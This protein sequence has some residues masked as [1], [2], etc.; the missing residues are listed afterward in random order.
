MTAALKAYAVLEKDE[1][2][3][4]IYFAHHGI[5]AAKWGANEYADGELGG[6]QCRRAKWADRF[7]ETGIPAR[8]AVEH[9]WHFE[10]FG[11]G[12]RIDSDLEY[13][14]RLPVSG[15]CGKVSGHVY[16]SPRC[17]WKHARDRDRRKAAEAA[18][19]EDFKAIVRRRFPDVEFAD[20]EDRF[21]GHHAY[22]TQH[23]GSGIWHRNQVIVEFNF[24]GM[25]IGPAQFRMSDR[26]KIGPPPAGYTCCNG[27]REAFEAYAAATRKV[28][29]P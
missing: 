14:H 10:C 17:K 5:I 20:G 18:A 27:D 8:V 2:T 21:H 25:M 1:Y 19:I 7:A 12:I 26:H 28:A 24:P 22:V 9:G 13:E 6:V 16:C 29:R 11:C 15:I 3:G 23:E 4:D